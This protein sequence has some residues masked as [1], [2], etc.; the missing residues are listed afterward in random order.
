M[1]PLMPNI[2]TFIDSRKY[3][4]LPESP[5]LM[6]TV[7]RNFDVPL[8]IGLERYSARSQALDP[9]IQPKGSIFKFKLTI[10]ISTRY[11]RSGAAIRLDRRCCAC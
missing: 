6:Q 7:F 9:W 10:K 11:N 8:S 2:L 3:H 4:T 1:E 5:R